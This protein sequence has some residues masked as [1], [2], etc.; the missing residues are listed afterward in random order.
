VIQKPRNCVEVFTIRLTGSMRQFVN[1]MGL[2]SIVMV[3]K[4]QYGAVDISLNLENL[5]GNLQTWRHH[6]TAIV[7][8]K[9]DVSAASV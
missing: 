7:D 8:F 5:Q 9:Y 3:I 6:V 2:S 4:Q 1:L